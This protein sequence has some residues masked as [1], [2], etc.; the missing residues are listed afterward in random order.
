VGSILLF[1][2]WFTAVRFL[3]KRAKITKFYGSFYAF[4]MLIWANVTLVTYE[5]FFCGHYL[6]LIFD[7]YY[8]DKY[9]AMKEYFFRP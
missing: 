1:G 4:L 9:L 2:F 6:C 7:K 5:I 3:Y 8:W